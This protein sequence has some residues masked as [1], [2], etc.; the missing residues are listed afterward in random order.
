MS[1]RPELASAP[2]LLYGMSGGAPEASGFAARNAARVAGLFLKV[3]ARMETL[4]TGN[5]LAVPTF[6]V[7]AELDTFV[8]NAMLT[9]AFRAN[10][11]AGALWALALEPGVPHHSLT[12]AQREITTLWMS[13]VLALRLGATASAPLREVY[14]S[15][16]WIG[17]IATGEVARADEFLDPAFG[18]WFPSAEIAERWKT[19]A[20]HRAPPGFS[21]SVEPTALTVR[22]GAVGSF[23]ASVADETGYYIDGPLVTLASQSEDVA[24]V[25]REV[26]CPMGCYT[27]GRVTGTAQGTSTVTVGYGGLTASVTVTVVP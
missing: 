7:L 21:L 17:D 6:V 19:F 12:P 5:I 1:G 23:T 8:D 24:Q 27:V 26:G 9:A 20:K 2:L 22:V 3:P 16:G 4:T 15:S 11:R 10:R 14:A 13:T 18:S 25:R